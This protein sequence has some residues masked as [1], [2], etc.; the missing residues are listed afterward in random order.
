MGPHPEKEIH[1]KEIESVCPES[2]QL[3][4]LSS[5]REKYGA[6]WWITLQAK[7]T[8]SSPK[9]EYKWPTNE[10]KVT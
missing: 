9:E 8:D 3:L 10:W 4:P 7:A 2:Q 6:K 1:E 5:F